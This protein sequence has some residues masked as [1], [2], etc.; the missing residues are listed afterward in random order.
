[1]KAPA[2]RGVCLRE[3][4]GDDS[5][6]YIM[7]LGAL[8]YKE[9]IA[10]STHFGIGTL[11]VSQ[12][13]TVVRWTPREAARPVCVRPAS[14][15][16]AMRVS[17][18]TESTPSVIL[19]AAGAIADIPHGPGALSVANDFR[20]EPAPD[21]IG[22]NGCVAG[23]AADAEVRIA[24][25]ER[26]C[27]G[28]RKSSDYL[29]AGLALASNDDSLSVAAS[30]VSGHFCSPCLGKPSVA[31]SYRER[32]NLYQLSQENLPEDHSLILPPAPTCTTNAAHG[33]GK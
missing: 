7:P 8:V 27:V 1:M 32:N 13:A 30:F 19:A 3:R 5:A 6:T 31:W 22:G 2:L 10:S 24:V 21:R 23:E 33:D 11:P 26:L 16:S 25:P 4:R 9:R 14:V 17:G 20:N 12:R 28:L 29:M 15:R 18:D